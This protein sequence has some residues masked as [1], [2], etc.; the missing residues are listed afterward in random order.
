MARGMSVC[1]LGDQRD[2]ATDSAKSRPGS[3]FRYGTRQHCR[4]RT[5]PSTKLAKQ[6]KKIED[7][8]PVL[9]RP[10]LCLGDRA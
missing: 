10:A 6:E 3:H 8:Q 7:S 1:R 2:R 4:G 9:I 5:D